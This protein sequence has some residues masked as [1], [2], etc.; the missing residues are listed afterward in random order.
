MLAI[1]YGTRVIDLWDLRSLRSQSG[2]MGLEWE[3]NES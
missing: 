1:A 3:R 2:K